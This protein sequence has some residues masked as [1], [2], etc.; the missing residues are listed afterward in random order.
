VTN[1]V[2]GSQMSGARAG[3]VAFV[4]STAGD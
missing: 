3:P 2:A 1:G 4:S